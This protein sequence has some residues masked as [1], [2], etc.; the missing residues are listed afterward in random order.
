MDNTTL[1]QRIYSEIGGETKSGLIKPM[2]LA[3]T[4]LAYIDLAR[5]LLDNDPANAEILKTSVVNQ[6]WASSKFTLPSNFLYHRPSP[7]KLYEGVILDIAGTN[8]FQVED[9]KK[10]GLISQTLVNAYYAIDGKFA[11]I[12]HPTLAGSSTLNLFYYKVPTVSDITDDVL[13]ILLTFIF[14][15][16]GL[17]QQAENEQQQPN[18][19]S[20]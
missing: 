13:N 3:I 20:S 1:L 9:R 17:K 2:V 11:Y 16:L 6:T 14:Q 12:K 15:R 18:S 10:L 4:D 8:A 7:E 5:H 19:Q